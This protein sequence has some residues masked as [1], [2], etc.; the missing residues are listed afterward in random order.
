M[1]DW[2]QALRLCLVIGPSEV[3]GDW[4]QVIDQAIAGGVSSVQLR[5]KTL[6][7]EIFMQLASMLLQRIPEH[8]ALIIND[9]V[10]VAQ[11]LGLS[12]HIGQRDCPY[13]KARQQLGEDAVI[14]L[15]IENIEQARRY[16]NCGANYFG[17][18]P[19]F[20]TVSKLDAAPVLGVS[21][22]ND[23]AEVL[24][25]SPSVFIGG[26]NQ[27]NVCQCQIAAGVAVIS[28]ITQ[29]HQPTMAA[30]QLTRG[31]YATA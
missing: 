13:D 10:S 30:Q 23:I 3:D 18:G 27:Q 24:Q 8:I 19:V 9:R 6:P 21:R 7:D 17:V 11:A 12:L 25:P 31:Y 1:I 16:K 26:I 29:S 20:A 22:A 28:A 5:D 4:L 2:Q 14:G 15:S